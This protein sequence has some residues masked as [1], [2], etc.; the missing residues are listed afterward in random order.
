ML[1]T[2]HKSIKKAADTLNLTPAQ[3]E[4]LLVV[5]AAHEVEL[6]LKSGKKLNAFR[7]QHSNARGPYKGGIR[8]HQDVDFD[9]VKALATLMSLKT[10]LVNVPLGG[11]K[12]GVE[13]DPKKLS[14]EELED[15]AREY[16]RKLEPHIGPE[17]DVPAPD[18]NTTAQIMDWMVDE[19]SN[20]TGDTSKASFTGKSLENGGS[21]GRPEATGRGG[22]YVLEK[23]LEIEGKIN[24]PMS[25]TVQG[26]GNVGAYFAELITGRFPK[27]K[28]ISVTDSS[29]GLLNTDGLDIV[30]LVE[31]KKNKKRF[32]D[33]EK[34]G[35]EHIDGHEIVGIEADILVLAALGGA[36]T[37]DTL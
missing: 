25:Y 15:I 17:K 22:L 14:A 7:M 27:W 13:V 37:T 4:E 30:D 28:L 29:G 3:V 16:V 19:Y 36:V 21:E 8:F 1:K 9:E 6:T 20:L 32:T 33:Y 12:G 26:F 10:A 34:V 11:G 18:V 23:L 2:A 31:Y 35:V 24:E 5:D